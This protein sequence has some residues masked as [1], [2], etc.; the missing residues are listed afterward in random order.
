MEVD[1]THVSSTDS[2]ASEYATCPANTSTAMDAEDMVQQ[3]IREAS[4][5]P[6]S[7]PILTR[8]VGIPSGNV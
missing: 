8:F 6:H 5:S 1:H 3:H 4:Q 7:V 2:A